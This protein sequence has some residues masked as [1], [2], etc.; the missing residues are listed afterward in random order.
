MMMLHAGR[1]SGKRTATDLNT[2]LKENVS[3]AYHSVQGEQLLERLKVDIEYDEAAGEIDV[4]PQGIGRVV[5]NLLS[6][7]F[8]AVQ[9]QAQHQSEA[10]IPTVR[11]A[12]R[13][14]KDHVQILVQDNGVGISQSVQSRIFEPF[15]TT[16]PAGRGTGL[17]LSLSYDIVTQGHGGTLTVD[18]REGRGATFVVALPAREPALTGVVV[19]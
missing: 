7:A 8:F 18:S 3:L 10:F 16:R 5:L 17:G 14:L 2:L 12:T 15:F 13:R 9:E 1:S 6:N 11:V 4:E 19:R